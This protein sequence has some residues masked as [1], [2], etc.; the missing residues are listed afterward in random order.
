[1]KKKEMYRFL[2]PLQKTEVGL[3]KAHQN[4]EGGLYSEWQSYPNRQP[5]AL[6]TAFIYIKIK[7]KTQIDGEINNVNTLHSAEKL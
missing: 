4:V 3:K 7:I 6:K 2:T 1:M 5:V